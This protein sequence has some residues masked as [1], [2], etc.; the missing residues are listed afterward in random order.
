[1]KLS[2]GQK[3]LF[4]VAFTVLVPLTVTEIVLRVTEYGSK[5]FWQPDPIYGKALIAKGEAW[6]TNEDRAF[7]RIND[8][9]YHDQNH[10]INKPENVFRIAVLG[11][12]FVEALQVPYQKTFWSL[13]AEKIEICDAL[14][15]KTIETLGFGVFNYGTGHQLLMLRNEVVQYQ[16]DEIVLGFF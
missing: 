16:P 7:V 14:S 4:L 2:V 3:T 5:A 10:Q 13:L 1:M 9:G 11:D 6:Y 8:Q 12:S 15:D